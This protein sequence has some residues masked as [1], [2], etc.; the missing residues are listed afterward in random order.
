MACTYRTAL[1][2]EFLLDA[3]RAP[4]IARLQQP[5]R[6]K[7]AGHRSAFCESSLRLSAN[8]RAVVYSTSRND[9]GAALRGLARVRRAGPTNFGDAFVTL[10]AQ[11][12]LLC[13]VP[14]RVSGLLA[15]AGQVLALNAALPDSACSHRAWPPPPHHLTQQ[16]FQHLDHRNNWII[17][18]FCLFSGATMVAADQHPQPPIQPAFPTGQTR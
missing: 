11:T 6:R 5:V 1:H 9:R 3:S 15:L 7:C 18:R 8:A 10:F 12:E 14:A 4:G 2:A 17:P 13:C 16:L